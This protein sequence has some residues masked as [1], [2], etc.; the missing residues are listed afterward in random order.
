[1]TD[2][3]LD[4]LAYEVLNLTMLNGAECKFCIYSDNPCGI[5]K[6]DTWAQ[7]TVDNRKPVNKKV[8]W[9]K[10]TYKWSSPIDVMI[11]REGIKKY[12]EEADNDKNTE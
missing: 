6:E 11:C 7:C 5:T 8:P 10:E 3:V 4:F 9:Q 2:R 1:M 12:F